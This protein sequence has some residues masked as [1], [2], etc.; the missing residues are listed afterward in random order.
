MCIRDSVYPSWSSYPNVSLCIFGK[1]GDLLI[2]EV[3]GDDLSL[4]HILMGETIY[5]GENQA[6]VLATY[7]HKR[8]QLG[9]GMMFPFTNN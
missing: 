4:I 7:T 9:A 1:G 8:L 5:K 2:G 6:A 3:I